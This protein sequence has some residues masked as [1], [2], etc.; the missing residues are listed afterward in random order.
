MRWVAIPLIALAGVMLA[1]GGQ[2]SVRQPDAGTPAP[3]F[4]HAAK[5]DWINSEPLSL[6]ALHG[7]VVLVDFWIFDCW[8]CYRSFSWL[9]G[10]HDRFAGE[11]H[12]GDRHAL[13]IER[14]IDELPSE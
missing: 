14:R 9:N 2:P 7:N 13:E 11:T 6:Q 10:L 12:A 5:S 3:E 1:S 8:N 4:T